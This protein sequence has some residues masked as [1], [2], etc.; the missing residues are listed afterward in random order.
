MQ[1]LFSIS[2]ITKPLSKPMFTSHLGGSVAFNWQQF[3]FKYE[4]NYSY[5]EFENY[6][7][8]ITTTTPRVK[9]G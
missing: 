4:S 5:N 1:K 3:H 8:K 7:F 2:D 6:T 9:L